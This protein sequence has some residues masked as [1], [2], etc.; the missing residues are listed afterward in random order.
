MAAQ[1]TFRN[2]RPLRRD[3]LWVYIAMISLPV[4][5]SPRM[6]TGM[7]ERATSCA[8]ASTSRMRLE[9]R[10]KEWL[11]LGGRVGV[12]FQEEDDLRFRREQMY[13]EADVVTHPNGMRFMALG[14]AS[15]VLAEEVFYSIGGGFIVSEAERIADAGG[16]AGGK[17]VV[18]YPFGSAAELLRI[19]DERG[20][21]V[22]E[23]VMA[24]ECALLADATVKIVRPVMESMPQGL[25]P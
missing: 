11:K 16:G 12:A 15:A 4:P 17:R 14:Y 18:P 7:S 19:A 2:I 9:V 22:A 5:L 10:T 25:K 1:L 8:W 21:S 23:V 6:S 24:N 20:L 3:I 13:P